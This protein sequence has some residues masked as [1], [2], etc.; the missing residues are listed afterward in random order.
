MGT[1]RF[2]PAAV[3][4]AVLL[5]AGPAA[6]AEV[7]VVA[8]G[9]DNPR[10]VSVGA[11]GA[12]YVAEAGRG[13]PR[14]EG[15]SCFD[16]AEGPSCVGATGAVTRVRGAGGGNPRARRVVTGLASFAPETGANAIGPHGIV[17]ESGVIVVTNGGPT[18]P[19]RAGAVVPRWQLAQENRVAARF[20]QVLWYR[21]RGGTLRRLG[22]IA[23]PYAFEAANNPDVTAGNALVDS[24]PVDVA[25]DGARIV[26]A[27][28]GGNSLLRTRVL[29]TV[30]ELLTLFPN[31]PEAAPDGT[32][33]PMNAVPTAVVMR[34]NAYYVSQLTGFP[35]PPLGAW[36]WRVNRRTGAARAMHKGKFTNIMDLAVDNQ[37]RLLVLE[38][39]HDSLLGPG[40]DGAL[41][42][43]DGSSVR[44]LDSPGQLTAPGGLDVARDGTIYISNRATEAGTGQLLRF[45]P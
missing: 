44:R 7:D 11:G 5:F 16:S 24:N 22:V 21:A 8:R 29:S 2:V 38:I 20:G 41:F 15:A 17:A 45:R 4:A 34:G 6:A 42:R 31:R 25:V 43:V 12:V 19:E 36:I 35:F 27:D 33:I 39:D 40:T 3:G 10:H 28:A 26:I 37:G 30:P 32:T 18:A 14:V 23:D 13:G 9:L 1:I